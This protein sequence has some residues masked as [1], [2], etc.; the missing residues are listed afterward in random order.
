MTFYIPVVGLQRKQKRHHE[1]RTFHICTDFKDIVCQND[2]ELG[3]T[4]SSDW[5]K[6]FEKNVFIDH[7][8]IKNIC[9]QT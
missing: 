3:G 9:K 5:I 4:L 6:T 8:V 2:I 1:K 7:E